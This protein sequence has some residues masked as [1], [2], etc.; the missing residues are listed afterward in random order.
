MT[1]NLIKGK[2]VNLRLVNEFDAEF[3]INLRL[4]KGEFLSQTDPDIKKQKDWIKEY[5]KRERNKEEFYFI[6]EDKQNNKLGSVRIYNINYKENR[7]TFGSF[8]I[9]KDLS[10][11]KYIALESITLAFDFSFNKL[12]LDH[13]YF[14]CR[15]NNKIANNFYNRYGI[16]IID[17][18]NMDY[19]YYYNKKYFIKDFQKHK[20]IYDTIS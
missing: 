8:I 7:F 10:N 20:F 4:K 6:I 13:C 12:G 11:D 19:F 3:I 9:D 14:D 1:I 15:K 2:N 17:E 18:D 16:S 5:K